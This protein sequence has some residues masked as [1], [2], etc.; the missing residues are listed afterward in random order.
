MLVMSIMPTSYSKWWLD[1]SAIKMLDVLIEVHWVIYK[2]IVRPKYPDFKITSAMIVANMVILAK[3]RQV[4]VIVSYRGFQATA[5]SV[6]KADIGQRI[7]SLIA[8]WICF[9]SIF[10][11]PLFSVLLSLEEDGH[12]NC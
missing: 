4:L 2:D 6:Q 8:T 12:N 10:S 1:L 11:A 3:N 9:I 7:G 5:A